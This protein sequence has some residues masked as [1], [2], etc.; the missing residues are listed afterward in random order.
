MRIGYLLDLNKGGYGQSLPGREDVHDTLHAMVDE[1]H[2]AEEAGFHSIGISDRH[3]RTE[4]YWP[5]PMQILSIL[6]RETQRVAIGTYCLV[7]TLWHPMVIAEQTAVA[8]N[9]SRGRFFHCLGR[10]YHPGYWDYFG[11]PHER[12][13]GRFLEGVR[14][15]EQAFESR[16]K[17][18]TF[19][20]DFYQ[21]KD[22]MLSPQPWQEHL[23]I[24]GSG[25]APPAIKRA[26]SYG[27]SW[28]GDPFPLEKA[29]WDK[30]VGAYR[31]AAEQ[32]G[33]KP[34]VIL[35]RDGWVADSF[36]DAM[37]EFGT[38]YLDEVRFYA[39]HGIVT[40]HPDFQHEEDF[41]PESTREHLVIG[42]ADE[43]IAQIE[44][45]RQ[46]YGVDYVMMRFRMTN[47][48]SFEAVREQL[49]R[50]GAEVCSHFNERYPAHDHPAI[51]EG[52][53]W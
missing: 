42:N 8:D 49:R 33:K 21:V 10:G 35:M 52:A 43:C 22:Q 1:A 17:P 27:D 48:P 11:I 29:T 26:A 30:E 5:G 32:R 19:D 3:G 14:C 18:F 28:A 25:Q 39:R 50:F 7:H 24:W 41:T 16:G 12:M 37:R 13:L 23:P 2:V 38:N 51:P 34:Y 47:G 53:R 46:E 44:K 20:G 40:H 6:A 31:E 45:Y 4:V 36:D 15:M 9:L